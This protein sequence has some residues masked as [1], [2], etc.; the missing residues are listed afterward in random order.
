MLKEDYS[1]WLNIFTKSELELATTIS[2]LETM[3]NRIPL[4]RQ[5]K[6][7]AEINRLKETMNCLNSLT[8]ELN[9]M[10]GDIRNE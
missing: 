9:N 8:K 1:L 10:K 3:I 2:N 5:A 7:I 6:L 4:S